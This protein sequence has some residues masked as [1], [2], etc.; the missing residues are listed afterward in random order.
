MYLAA[1]SVLDC[2]ASL[3]K[4]VLVR[5]ELQDVEFWNAFEVLDVRCGDDLLMASSAAVNASA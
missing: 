4:L 2:E 1:K 5:R 3:R